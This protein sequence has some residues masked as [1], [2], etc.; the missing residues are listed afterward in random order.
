MPNEIPTRYP[1]SVIE[2]LRAALADHRSRQSADDDL[3]IRFDMGSPL[4]NAGY[5]T[6]PADPASCGRVTPALRLYSVSAD[7]FAAAVGQSL[8]PIRAWARSERQTRPAKNLFDPAWYELIH[9]D[10]NQVPTGAAL[11]GAVRATTTARR[12]RI[13]VRWG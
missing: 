4:G 2:F 1:R 5:L 11:A 13:R 8:D 3:V 10:V 7:H 12:L 9:L 6:Y